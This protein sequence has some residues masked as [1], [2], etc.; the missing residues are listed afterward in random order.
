MGGV[1]QAKASMDVN[2]VIVKNVLA[3]KYRVLFYPLAHC[4]FIMFEKLVL[5][6]RLAFLNHRPSTS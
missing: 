3:A 1:L 4:C 5:C 2:F 6:E